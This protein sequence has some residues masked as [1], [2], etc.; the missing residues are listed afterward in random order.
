MFNIR[1]KH[2]EQD[3]AAVHAAYGDVVEGLTFDFA[4][5]D[6]GGILAT[7]GCLGPLGI[8]LTSYERR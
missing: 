3:L 5:Q 4:D 6:T 8:M 1:A 2:I 7:G